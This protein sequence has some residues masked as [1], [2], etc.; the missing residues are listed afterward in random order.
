MTREPLEV[1]SRMWV[2]EA[3]MPVITPVITREEDTGSPSGRM[4][5]QGI[6]KTLAADPGGNGD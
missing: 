4:T 6:D 1:W 3:G 2:R 5:R